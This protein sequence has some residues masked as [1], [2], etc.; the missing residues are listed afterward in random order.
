MSHVPHIEWLHSVFGWFPLWAVKP[1][2]TAVMDEVKSTLNL[3]GPCSIDFLAEGSFNKVYVVTHADGEVVARIAMPLD[4]KWKTLSEVATIQW[5]HENTSLPVP[6]VLGY[7][8]DRTNRTGL[9]WIIMEKV[10]GKP[11]DEVWNEVSFSA[12]KQLVHD[13]A[14]FY[15]DTFA[16]QFRGIGNIFPQPAAA[17]NQGDEKSGTNY[18]ETPLAP[19]LT[20]Q[21]LVCHQNKGEYPDPDVSHEPFASSREWVSARLDLIEVQCTM[22]LKHLRHAAGSSDEGT[23]DDSSGT[24]VTDKEEEKFGLENKL[25]VI[26]RLR[27]HLADFFPAGSLEPEPSVIFHSDM[28]SGNVLVDQTGKLTAVVDWECVSALPLWAACEYPEFL[29]GRPNDHCPINSEYDHDENGEVEENFWD[30][31]ENFEKTQLRRSFLAEMER[32]QPDWV[33]TQRSTERQRDFSFAVVTCAEFR[34]PG[35]ISYWLNDV[36]AGVEG[37][38]GLRYQSYQGIF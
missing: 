13:I 1:D 25:E 27:H 4:P 5:V 30:D 34:G 24:D 22:R 7:S 19:G 29:I 8:A 11:Y 37:N 20:V 17:Q 38:G 9:E 26:S 21:R 32:L 14:K 23:G 31:L 12:K 36:E 33:A 35:S 2:E 15:S 28:N 18:D 3:Q 10:P 16:H 6:R